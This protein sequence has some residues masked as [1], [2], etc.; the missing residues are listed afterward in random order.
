M[1]DKP[2]EIDLEDVER[3]I[4]DEEIRTQTE[5][6]R[7]PPPLVSRVNIPTSIASWYPEVE[8]TSV[9]MPDT[10]SINL[11]RSGSGMPDF[12]N[13]KVRQAA[14][15][16]GGTAHVR[17][18]LSGGR[19]AHRVVAD[20]EDVEM[21]ICHILS[22]HAMMN[23]PHGSTVYLREWLDLDRAPDE[24]TTRH[25][26]VRFFIRDGSVV[27]WHIRMDEMNDPGEAQPNCVTE[28]KKAVLNDGETLLSYAQEVADHFDA[29]Y[30]FDSD[31]PTHDDKT[32]S[33]WSV[34]FVQNTSGKWYLTDMAVDA[35]CNGHETPSADDEFYSLSGHPSDECYH[36]VEHE[37][38][39][40]PDE[41]VSGGTK[42]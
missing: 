20:A 15:S 29:H 10:T 32:F 36:N 19:K 26:E 37:T 11:D 7:D 28:A 4:A 3:H 13:Q 17:C 1:S 27:C 40:T 21:P 5:P 6:T 14:D 12:D 31:H 33:W 16:V 42:E 2:D 22:D 38:W 8:K 35:L 24:R 18:A 23:L 30:R 39:P 9:P 34:D 25:P 41:S